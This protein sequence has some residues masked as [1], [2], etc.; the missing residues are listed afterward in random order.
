[1]EKEAIPTQRKG[2]HFDVRQTRNMEEREDAKVQ[3]ERAKTR[4]LD[5]TRWGDFSHEA[6]DTFVLTDALGNVVQRP[7]Q[8]GDHIKVHLP[9]PR[10]ASGD[11]ADWVVI[12]KIVEQ[13]NKLLDE[14]FT[15]M[16][17]RPCPNPHLN[18]KIVAHFYDDRSTNTFLVCRHKIQ[19]ICSIHGRNELVNTDTNW[20]DYL[21]NLLIALP[22]KAGLSNPHWLQLAKGLIDL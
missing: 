19:L 10:S 3:Y 11:G 9:G 17:V 4:L 21:R 18:S 16:A 13:R 22:A 2:A 1:M 7:A 6:A 14:I 5:V 20:L 8:Q 12:E 15:G